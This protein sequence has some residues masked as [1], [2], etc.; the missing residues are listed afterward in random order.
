[1]SINGTM[2][3]YF[4][5]DLPADG[6]LW[7]QL[8]K[9]ADK[10]KTAGITAVWMPPAYKAA[11]GKQDVGYGVYDLY[12]LGEFNQKGT[13]ETKYGT[14]DEYLAAIKKLHEK[15][16]CA[17][18]DVVL[19][20]KIGADEVEQVS[21]AEFNENSRNQMIGD[22]RVIGAWTKFTF[23]GRAGKYSDFTWNWKHFDGIDWD[24]D[25][26]KKSIFC[27][28]GK[29]WD[30]NV[31]NE[32][33]NYD[34]LMG[35]D[36]DFTNREVCEELIRWGK[37]YTD[38]TGVDGYRLDAVK[39][40]NKYYYKDWMREMKAAAERD[41]FAVGEY[42][43]WDVNVLQDYI[44]A[45]EGE[46]KLFD[47][48]LHFNFHNCSKAHGSYDLRTIFDGTLT[49]VNPLCAVT[50]V[51]N[52]DSQPGQALFS[53]VE[54]WFKP[55]AYAMILL[56]EQGYPCVFYGDYMGIPTSNVK[57]MKTLLNKLLKIRKLKAYGTQHDYFDDPNCIGW[58]R[59]G[60]LEHKDSGIAVVISDGTGGTKHM[61]IGKQFAGCHFA[62][63][64][65]NAKYNIKI[66]EDGFGDFYVNRDSVAVWVRKENRK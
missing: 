21:A 17:Y 40:I 16:I 66:D 63:A 29:D 52:H 42:W 57:S 61:Y 24:Q 27:F 5:W 6:T 48:P 10:L 12:D 30:G 33:G 13:I 14:K 9:D 55:M 64:L 22:Q 44:A 46:V 49:K 37:W 23:P 32:C 2:M 38:F 36:I 50:F 60:D 25:R 47:V 18:A 15:G 41:L 39:H 34:Y 35:A 3:Q 8:A 7:K 28:A 59:E 62:D 43:H 65:G 20:H 51:D 54:D 26:A 31:D 45:T 1:M 53:W 56:R 4:E 11:G 19:N 58:T